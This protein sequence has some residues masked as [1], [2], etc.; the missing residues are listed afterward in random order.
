M[1]LGS[2]SLNYVRKLWEDHSKMVRALRV[3]APDF[4][5][6][7]V[8]KHAFEYTTCSLFSSKGHE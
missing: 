4:F 1:T 6:R 7:V 2:L 5:K 8:H 3:Q